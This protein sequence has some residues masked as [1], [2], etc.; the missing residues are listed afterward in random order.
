[1]KTLPAALIVALLCTQSVLAQTSFDFSL[2]SGD[3][4]AGFGS[5]NS[6]GSS[7]TRFDNGSTQGYFLVQGGA[8]KYGTT[9]TAN[10]AWIVYDDAQPTVSNAT[11]PAGYEQFQA[12]SSLVIRTQLISLS[13]GTTNNA[14]S[15]GI[16]IGLSD[17][18]N[19]ANGLLFSVKNT[20]NTSTSDDFLFLNSFTGG[21][22]GSNI[23]SSS[24]FAYGSSS[25]VYFMQLVLTP[26]ADGTS[27]N[28]SF[29]LIAD[30]AIPGSGTGISRLSDA[31]FTNPTVICSIDGVLNSAQYTNGYVGLYYEG[32]G[33]GSTTGIVNYT[34]FYINAVPEPTVS[35]LVPASLLCLFARSKFSGHKSYLR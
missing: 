3:R 18:S 12:G 9:A 16:L 10:S 31:A 33:T 24:S 14:A 35:L 7:T 23:S 32:D 8:L 15:T 29:Q 4:Q 5:G 21:A 34:N 13:S 26:N 30:S 11:R 20:V 1:M 28:Y 19:T 25:T 22:V 2:G 6:S 17:S 27:T